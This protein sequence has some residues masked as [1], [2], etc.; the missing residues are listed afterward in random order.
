M[1]KPS[2]VLTGAEIPPGGSANAAFSRSG[3][4]SP[5]ASFPR[6]PPADRVGAAEYCRARAEKSSPALARVCTSRTRAAACGSSFLMRISWSVTVAGFVY[7]VPFL[8][9]Y[10]AFTSSSVTVTFVSTSRPRTIRRSML[11]STFLFRS[12]YDIPSRLSASWSASSPSMLFSF[13]MPSMTSFTTSGRS[14]SPASSAR[15][16]SRRSSTASWR[17]RA[18]FSRRKLST[19]SGETRAFWAAATWRDWNSVRVTISPLTLA[20]MRSRIS[21][22]AET[23]KALRRTR[24]RISRCMVH[25]CP[26]QEVRDEL[27]DLPIRLLTCE[28][29][30]DGALGLLERRAP[31][32]LARLD[33]EDVEAEG[34]LHDVA[35]PSGGEREGRGLEL[36]RKLAAGE[37]AH[38][39]AGRGLRSA[40]ERAGKDLE[41]LRLLE[42]PAPNVPRLVRGRDEDLAEGHG[43]GLLELLGVLL[44]VA[45]DLVRADLHAGHVR[46]QP[47]DRTLLL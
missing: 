24:G 37:R 23:E 38:E 19:R 20:T 46:Q 45:R 21:A 26:G 43:L 25:L 41:A 7:S 32:G 36:R 28:E 9:S 11:R 31:L 3:L 34:R 15:W 40:G 4:S 16:E 5:W 13:L 6:S 33:P 12:S 27:A 47:L 8:A 14:L 2:L 1:R 30:S 42:E 22:R 35:G 10:S 17:M 29:L 18:L 39:P 44:V